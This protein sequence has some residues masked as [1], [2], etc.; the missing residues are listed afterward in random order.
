MLD[1]KAKKSLDEAANSGLLRQL[2]QHRANA[3]NFSHNDYLGLSQHPALVE[4]S[5]EY[6]EKYG[7]GS[8]ASRVLG[9]NMK[10]HL[11]LEQAIAQ[12]YSGKQ[13]LVFAS[14]FQANTTIISALVTEKLH[15]IKALVLADEQCH[16]SMITGCQLGGAR[17]YRYRHQDLQHLEALLKRPTVGPRFVMTETVFSMSGSVTNMAKLASLAKKHD[18]YTIIDDA[19]GIGITGPDGY[20]LAQPHIGNI[21]MLVGTFS[22]ALGSFGAYCVCSQELKNY[23]VNYCRGFIYTT[24]PSPAMVGA[25]QAGWDLLPHLGEARARLQQNTKKIRQILKQTNWT[26]GETTSSIIP[27]YNCGNLSIAK[28]HEHL[29][30]HDI[31]TGFVR[32]PTTKAN[33]LRITAS[34]AHRQQDVADFAKAINNAHEQS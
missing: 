17:I 15:G 20:G 19:H 31:I 30:N 14:G 4:K 13:A 26:H 18:A 9:G 32:P 6:M 8:T 29:Q 1:I 11:E 25:M 28:A 34:A 22:K 23:L 27:V 5:L 7:A 16:N 2:C 33:M 3:V 10:Y 12:S 24:A 21:D